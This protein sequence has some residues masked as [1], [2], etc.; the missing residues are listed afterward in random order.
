[1]GSRRRRRKLEQ[2]RA[3][4]QQV[5]RLLE[6]FGK[7]FEDLLFANLPKE[8][9]YAKEGI[10]YRYQTLGRSE[11]TSRY[12]EEYRNVPHAEELC[13]YLMA[14]AITNVSTP[15]GGIRSEALYLTMKELYEDSDLFRKY[16]AGE[17]KDVK[18]IAKIVEDLERRYTEKTGKPLP[19]EQRELVR[20]W[21]RLVNRW[22]SLRTRYRDLL[23]YLARFERVQE[24]L[25][26]L[27][28]EVLS[29]VKG[30]R[31]TKS[32]RL[33]VKWCL[34]PKIT[35]PLAVE[36]CR[37]GLW[38]EYV[39]PIDM[40]TAL[41]VLRSGLFT[42]ILSEKSALL[43]AKLEEAREQGTEYRIKLEKV[44]D[45]VQ[46]VLHL[47]QDPIALENALHLIGYRYCRAG[48]C[49]HCPLKDYCRHYPV[50]VK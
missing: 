34:H 35:V 25:Q 15:R 33:L 19:L 43:Q 2:L 14:V 28:T 45:L 46:R 23:N 16:I 38:R 5:V 24:M 1:M 22:T 39:A 10:R 41:V 18:S 27:S 17:V 9:T 50:K 30:A 31:T 21:T 4:A 11:P 48:D 13:R 3:Q 47:G 8:L 37:R 36:I 29:V 7:S 49:E 40:Y 44:D 12:V 20:S 32:C 26:K 6:E 42:Y